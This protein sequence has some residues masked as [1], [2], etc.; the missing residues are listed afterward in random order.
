M[1]V[2]NNINQKLNEVL[3][4]SLTM[5]NQYFLHARMLEDWGFEELGGKNFKYSIKAMKESDAMIKR[6]L[7]LEGLPNLQD[8]G[9][10]SIGENVSEIL[11]GNLTMETQFR[12]VLQSAI[13]EAEGEK[14]Y[15]T[16]DHLKECLEECEERLDY[17]ETQIDLFSKV[18]TDNYHQSIM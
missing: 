12:S 9:K 6:I 3:K 8:L 11:D 2:D 5:I 7:F 10:L 1:K 17:F 18:G 16:R 15:V 4:D 13:S 14:D